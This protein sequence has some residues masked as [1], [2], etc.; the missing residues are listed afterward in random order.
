[1]TNLD[2]MKGGESEHISMLSYNNR[3]FYENDIVILGSVI[4]ERENHEFYSVSFD[5]FV[6]Y[7]NTPVKV[8]KYLPSTKVFST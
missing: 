8:N 5:P 4:F 7:Q 2:L 3:V 1:M 6:Y